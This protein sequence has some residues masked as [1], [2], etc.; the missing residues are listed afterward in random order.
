MTAFLRTRAGKIVL[1]LLGVAFTIPIVL[2]Y[3][4]VM[5]DF[6]EH[7]QRCFFL[8]QWFKGA[9]PSPFYQPD[10]HY[11]PNL[12]MELTVIPLSFLI[13]VD[14]A[15]KLF[16][17]LAAVLP[18]F[19]A[20]YIQRQLSGRWT[21]WSL[22]PAVLLYNHVFEFGF[23]NYLT[24]V[25]LALVGVGVHLKLANAPTW[26]R[27][28]AAAFFAVVVLT[29]HL[30]G[31]IV[32]CGSVIMVDLAS[33]D[34][35]NP[36]NKAGRLGR[37]LT[38][39]VAVVV[40]GAL[41]M[42]TI[43]RKTATTEIE[44]Y[45]LGVKLFYFLEPLSDMTTTAGTAM[46]VLLDLAVITLAAFRAVKLDRRLLPAILFWGSTI[47]WFP[48]SYGQNG[49]FIDMRMAIV[50]TLFLY[51][52]STPRFRERWHRG[53]ATALLAATAAV[54]W[55]QHVYKDQRANELFPRVRKDFASLPP[56]SAVLVLSPASIKPMKEQSW[57]PPLLH[58]P[59]LAKRDD[60]FVSNFFGD[61]EEQ[62]VV[63]RPALHRLHYQRLL[64]FYSENEWLMK[65]GQAK[66]VQLTTLPPDERPS[67][68]YLYLLGPNWIQDSNQMR[69]VD[70]MDSFWI[71][72]INPNLW[73]P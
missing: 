24:G 52:G 70:G 6:P 20:S 26:K 38:P 12:A 51:A 55:G 41:I 19:G 28:V 49:V 4:P 69:L 31:F 60:V 53:L 62:P 7:V 1:L 67:H 56:D 5:V 3:C 39:D 15:A 29:A 32:F 33:F 8:Q 14:W 47:F 54:S 17:V 61:E 42:L 36:T 66:F 30:G 59:A 37:F 10:I 22:V 63:F 18:C 73:S 46:Q 44:Y 71:Y 68:L 16:A 64:V 23:V 34:W 40:V 9:P 72:E 65:D 48:N 11:V 45:G 35:S 25:G 58:A 2:A 27:V 57:Y 50:F 13:G 43:G 21:L